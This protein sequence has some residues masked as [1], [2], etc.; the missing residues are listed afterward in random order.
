MRIFFWLFLRVTRAGRVLVS[1]GPLLYPYEHTEY[2]GVV[3]V[4][5]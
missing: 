4:R 5:S 1:A 3:P 2:D